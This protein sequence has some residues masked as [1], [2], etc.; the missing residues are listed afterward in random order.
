MADRELLARHGFR[1]TKAMGQ[2]FLTDIRVP[3][4]M[5]EAAGLTRDHGAVEHPLP[6]GRRAAHP[7]PRGF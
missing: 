2:N 7:P 4:R 3:E 6:Q 1:F 5:A